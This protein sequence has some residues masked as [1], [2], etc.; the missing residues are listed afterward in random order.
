MVERHNMT[1]ERQV[2]RMV[3]GKPPPGHMGDQYG[4]IAFM[5]G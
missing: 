3:Y 4:I 2:T 1:I 5:T